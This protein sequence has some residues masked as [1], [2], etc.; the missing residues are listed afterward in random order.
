MIE[1]RVHDEIQKR[2]LASLGSNDMK[3]RPDAPVFNKD[4]TPRKPMGRPPRSMAQNPIELTPHAN[5]EEPRPIQDYLC[6]D[7]QTI[8]RDSQIAQS[9]R[10]VQ[11]IDQRKT[12][13]PDDT[14]AAVN[15]LTNNLRDLSGRLNSLEVANRHGYRV[16]VDKDFD[17]AVIEARL[18]HLEK[19]IIELPE[20]TTTSEP[21][22]TLITLTAIPA[23]DWE[24]AVR[25][26]YGKFLK[27]YG[28]PGCSKAVREL[29]FLGAMEIE[30]RCPSLVEKC[31]NVS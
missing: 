1:M 2:T 20:K 24:G 27:I 18:S 10:A 23:D 9:D 5:Y 7:S 25:T 16:K 12:N 26:I 17:P 19:M 30:A 6:R 3:A 14:Q 22:P 13:M 15:I 11:F 28:D 29:S 31:K 8:L 21:E 4:G